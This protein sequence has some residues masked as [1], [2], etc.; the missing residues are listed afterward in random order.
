[1]G[2]LQKIIRSTWDKKAN[3]LALEPFKNGESAA[4]NFSY[5]SPYDVLEAPIQAALNLAAKQ[6]INPQEVD[7]YVLSQLFGS[8]G[9][10]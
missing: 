5:F 7:S 9:L 10:L 4:I 1:M 6:K 2:R 8:E 3:L